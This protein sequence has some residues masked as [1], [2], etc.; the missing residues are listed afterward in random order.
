MEKPRHKRSI[1]HAAAGLVLA[2]VLLG[3]IGLGP[4]APAAEATSVEYKIKAGYLLKFASFV[5]W[6]TNAFPSP[7]TPI[8][9][10]VLGKDPFGADLDS[11]IGGKCVEGRA[12]RIRRFDEGDDVSGCHILFISSSER[13]RLPQ[14]LDG[15]KNSCTLTVSESDEFTQSGGMISFVRQENTIRFEINVE[16]A[17]RAGL[18]LSSKLLQVAKLSEARRKN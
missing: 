7:A 16:A 12:L 3:A 2:V 11:T 6:P 4:S 18:K 15:L 13:K 8:I 1:G 9:L 10:G 5:E 14:I 17:R